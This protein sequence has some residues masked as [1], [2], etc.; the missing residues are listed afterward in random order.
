MMEVAE[1]P[2]FE[3][4]IEQVRD[5]V[6]Q[7]LDI[8]TDWV[9]FYR[10]VLGVGGMLDELFATREERVRFEQTEEYAKIQQAVAK[11]REK[12]KQAKDTCEEATRVITVR[13]PKSLHEALRNEAHNH[14]TS[15]NQLCISKLLQFIDGDLVPSDVQ[16]SR[17]ERS[18]RSRAAGRTT[19]EVPPE[20]EDREPEP[21]SDLSSS[22]LAIGGVSFSPYADSM[23]GGRPF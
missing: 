14:R 10:E 20:V 3:E 11:L 22:P 9:L 6:Q 12:S 18:A 8:E 15:M 17:S 19:V 2:R 5:A 21:L 13:L 16:P 4:R 1:K 7:R 23:T